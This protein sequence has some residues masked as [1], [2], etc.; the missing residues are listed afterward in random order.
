MNDTTFVHKQKENMDLISTLDP[1][2]I[3]DCKKQYPTVAVQH[4]LVSLNRKL[5]EKGME[6]VQVEG[7]GRN[8]NKKKMDFCEALCEARK[9]LRSCAQDGEKKSTKEKDLVVEKSLATPQRHSALSWH[10][11]STVDRFF[12]S[13]LKASHMTSEIRAKTVFGSL[14]TVEVKTTT[15]EDDASSLEERIENE[16]EWDHEIGELLKSFASPILQGP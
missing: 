3:H 5:Y 13:S 9:L 4:E 15:V 6:V 2:R 7:T 11:M 12:A 8:G 10:N 1:K 16:M 14:E